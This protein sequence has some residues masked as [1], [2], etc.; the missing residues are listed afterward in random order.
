[1]LPSGAN[2]LQWMRSGT[3]II[4]IPR[5]LGAK[6]GVS[7]GREVWVS[8]ALWDLCVKRN[9]R[10]SRNDARKVDVLVVESLKRDY[11]AA[12]DGPAKIRRRD[13]AHS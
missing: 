3:P 11:R 7:D 8:L 13:D 9:N 2:L 6:R 10:Q 4:A 1:M 5:M 12:F